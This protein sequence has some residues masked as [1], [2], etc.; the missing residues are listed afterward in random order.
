MVI[1]EWRIG[2]DLVGSGRGLI[3]RYYPDIR[4]EGLRKTTKHLSQDSQSPSRDLIAGPPAFEV[5][6]LTTRP[7]RS[8]SVYTS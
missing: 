7:R 5:G 1:N 4:L 6:V 3:L 2:Y 8:V